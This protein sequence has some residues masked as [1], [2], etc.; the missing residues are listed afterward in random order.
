VA[1]V[2]AEERNAAEILL[3]T[4]RLVWIKQKLEPWYVGIVWTVLEDVVGV[5]Y[6][7]KKGT[8][9]YIAMKE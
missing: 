1:L 7:D 6:L 4:G 3:K 5:C 9:D 8:F 2:L